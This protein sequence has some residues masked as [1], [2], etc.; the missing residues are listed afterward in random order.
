MEEQKGKKKKARVGE[1]P[2]LPAVVLKYVET[3]PLEALSHLKN[4]VEMQAKKRKVMEDME[5]WQR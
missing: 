4:I 2:N 5:E 1:G 3:A